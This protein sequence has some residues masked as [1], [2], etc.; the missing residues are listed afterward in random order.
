MS[1]P[2]DIVLEMAKPYLDTRQND[3]H[4]VVSYGFAQRLL[5]FYPEADAEVVLPAV[6][7]H[8][9]GWKMVPED[10]QLNA[11]GPNMNNKEL[12]RL[13]ETE[14]ARI[15]SEILESLDYDTEKIEEIASIIDGHD[16]R[17]KALSLND[18]IV[19][20]ADKL[21]RYSPVG[22]SVDH[23]RFNMDRQDYIVMVERLIDR[24]FFTDK[25]KEMARTALSETGN[26]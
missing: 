2:Y 8:D 7:L 3:L 6:I 5:D 24:W 9:L 21:W 12:Q 20:D 1:S 16:T 4:T 18:A 11:F 10:E 26:S 22:V 19:K 25:A 23:S 17:R 14:G 13:H 15:A